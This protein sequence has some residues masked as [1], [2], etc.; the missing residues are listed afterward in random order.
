MS[1][2]VLGNVFRGKDMIA[3][4]SI[5]LVDD[6]K[7]LWSVLNTHGG[8]KGFICLLVFETGSLWPGCPVIHYVAQD[9]LKHPAVLLP[10]PTEC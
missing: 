6:Q 4:L 5:T 8:K 9:G 7:R 3:I 1:L 2:R 10:Q